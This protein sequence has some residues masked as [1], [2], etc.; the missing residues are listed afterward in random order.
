MGYDEVTGLWVGYCTHAAWIDRDT[1]CV[2]LNIVP[3]IFSLFYLC[4]ILG[5]ASLLWGTSYMVLGPTL[6]GYIVHVAIADGEPCLC[7]GLAIQG[8]AIILAAL[9]MIR[10]CC[11]R[12]LRGAAGGIELEPTELFADDIAGALADVQGAMTPR[13]VTPRDGHASFRAQRQPVPPLQC[14]GV[15]GGIFTSRSAGAYTHRSMG[16]Y[17]ARS[18]GSSTARS[19]GAYTSRSTSDYGGM[20]SARSGAYC[21]HSLPQEP[22]GT[23]QQEPPNVH[24]ESYG[25]YVQAGGLP[26]HSGYSSAAAGDGSYH[27][28]LSMEPSAQLLEQQMQVRV[29]G[30][31]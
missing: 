15:D 20:Y 6:F 11:L 18:A 3:I 24:L 1:C 31:G 2:T 16:P 9:A 13:D 28:N 25:Q 30:E 26:I 4:L 7:V 27:P 14:G 5:C 23:P 10:R 12:R 17:S 29:H 21:A 8:I 22:W 19:A